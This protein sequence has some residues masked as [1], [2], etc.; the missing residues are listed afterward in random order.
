[1]PAIYLNGATLMTTAT[2]RVIQIARDTGYV[3]IEA[4]AERLLKDA[5]EVRA[6]AEMVRPSE[7]LTL[8]GVALT[9][10]AD[11]RMDRRLIEDDLKPRLQVCQDLGAPYLL[12]I[13]PR[14]PGLD[15]RRAIPGTRDALQLAR[16][17][18]DRL[19][20]RI[21]FEF[22]GFGDCPI[23]TPEIASETVDGIDGID[24]VLD[25]CH[26]HA[27][28]SQPLN[29]F[30]VD[31]LALVHFNDAPDKPPRQIEDE[32]R[33]LPGEGVIKLKTLTAALTSRGYSEPWSLE[34]FNPAYWKDDPQAIAGRGLEAITRILA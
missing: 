12:A 16:D 13:P 28:G 17:R 29:S 6:T 3:G 33:V 8:N 22:L 14:A 9:V 5:A 24:L 20:I 1:M 15:T 30:P 23:N 18:A 31:R 11:G 26:W 10:Q 2:P 4:R 25:S 19:G 21:A 27:S 32:D 7:V 34:T